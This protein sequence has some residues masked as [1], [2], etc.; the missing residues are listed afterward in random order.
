MGSHEV[1]SNRDRNLRFGTTNWTLIAAAQG[2]DRPEARQALADLCA[3]YWYPLYAYLRQKGYPADRA[4]DL[5]QGFFASLLAHDFLAEIA[6][7]KGKFRSFLL[8]SLQNYLANQHVRDHA[9]KRGR[10]HATLSID[11]P[12]AE[13]RYA[14]E[15]SHALTA[16]RLF[17]RRWALT[18]LERALDQLG[19][20]MAGS[21]KGPIFERLGPALMGEGEAASYAQVAAELAMTEGAVKVAAYRL[22]R[23]FR[24]L[25]RDEVARTVERPEEVDDEIHALFAA[26]SQ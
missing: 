16:E 3:V 7:E 19:A 10:G 13:G 22:R 18:L 6:P 8:R 2:V 11:L 23:R 12:D 14:Y 17:E 9:G 21:Q 15:P 24:E 26:L 5:T 25:V 20:E 4:Q 1:G